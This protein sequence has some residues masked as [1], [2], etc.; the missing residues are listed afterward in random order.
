MKVKFLKKVQCRL[1]CV[2]P[3]V[4]R[5]EAFAGEF[6]DVVYL[7][8]VFKCRVAGFTQVGDSSDGTFWNRFRE[9]FEAQTVSC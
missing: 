5:A 3:E 1:C 8:E 6:L 7:Q 9:T 2:I 4:A